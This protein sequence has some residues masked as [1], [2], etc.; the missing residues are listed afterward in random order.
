M[1][2]AVEL[3]T[4]VALG[5][6]STNPFV[7]RQLGRHVGWLCRS[8]C[9]GPASSNS[10]RQAHKPKHIIDHQSIFDGLFKQTKH[11]LF[12]V[13]LCDLLHPHGRDD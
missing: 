1:H 12:I 4:R 6:G 2:W 10:R 5:A 9:R 8:D 13:G 11:A 3:R 7:K